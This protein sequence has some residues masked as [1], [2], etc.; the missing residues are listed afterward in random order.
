MN[1]LQFDSELTVSE[2]GSQLIIRNNKLS[3]NPIYFFDETPEEI[4]E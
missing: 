4:N 2:D 1:N 3:T